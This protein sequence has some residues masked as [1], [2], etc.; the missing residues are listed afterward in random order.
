MQQQIQ[1]YVDAGMD[2]SSQDEAEEAWM[3]FVKE[4]K[5]LFYSTAFCS[6]YI[7]VT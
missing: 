3:D 2:V 6:L 1:S 7:T 5:L 4:F